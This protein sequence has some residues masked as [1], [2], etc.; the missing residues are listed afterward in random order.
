MFPIGHM[1]YATVGVVGA[2][3]FVSAW[4]LSRYSHWTR[5]RVLIAAALPLPGI[6]GT[7]CVVLFLHAAFS[8]RQACGVDACGMA[9]AAAI[10]GL[11]LAVMAFAVGL[12][13]ASV[14]LK[15]ARG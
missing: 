5:R 4:L 12:G 11:F 8:S 9:M 14:A 6:V 7:L 1:E 3:A 10:T 13:L 2:F 15:L